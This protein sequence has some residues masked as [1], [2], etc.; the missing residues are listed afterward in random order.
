MAGVDSPGTTSVPCRQILTPL[1]TNLAGVDREHKE[2]GNM[3]GG[4]DM[5]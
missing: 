2:R 4:E 1:P 5:S 3:G